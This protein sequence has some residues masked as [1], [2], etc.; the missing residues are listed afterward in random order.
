MGFWNFHVNAKGPDGALTHREAKTANVAAP[1]RCF[2]QSHVGRPCRLSMMAMREGM[3]RFP[4]HRPIP[5]VFRPKPSAPPFGAARR[6]SHNPDLD[7]VPADLEAPVGSYLDMGDVPAGRGP[8]R[9]SSP[10]RGD[11][12]PNRLDRRH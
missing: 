7:A 5:A 1:A 12:I 9:S 11:G 6:G 3:N 10:R 4:W 2:R 8:E